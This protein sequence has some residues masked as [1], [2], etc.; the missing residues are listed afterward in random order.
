MKSETVKSK[1]KKRLQG[2]QAKQ[3]GFTF[4]KRLST[5]GLQGYEITLQLWVS[6]VHE[7]QVI[8]DEVSAA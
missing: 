4:L 7:G 2:N 5:D 3:G 8:L 6:Y 1:R